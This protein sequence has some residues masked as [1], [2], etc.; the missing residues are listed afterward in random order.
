MFSAK[1]WGQEC[2]LD[3]YTD[4]IDEDGEFTKAV[5]NKIAKHSKPELA[6]KLIVLPGKVWLP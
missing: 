6:A 3:R 4:P 2:V 5:L 1:F